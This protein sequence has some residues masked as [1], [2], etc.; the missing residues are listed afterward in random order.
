[1]KNLPL[2][3]ALCAAAFATAGMIAHPANPLTIMGKKIPMTPNANVFPYP[4][5]PPDCGAR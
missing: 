1:M 4:D 2:I 5:C 3:L